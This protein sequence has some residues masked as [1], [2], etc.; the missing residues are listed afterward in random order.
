MTL[1]ALISNGQFDSII[2]IDNKIDSLKKQKDY[3][4]DSVKSSIENEISILEKDLQESKDKI[5]LNTKEKAVK[6]ELQLKSLEDSI[7]TIEDSF[8]RREYNYIKSSLVGHDKLSELKN[9]RNIILGFINL[10]MSVSE[11]EKKELELEY[12]D[13][14]SEMWEKK[15]KII[16][17][18]E[19]FYDT[20]IL[21]LEKQKEQ[22]TANNP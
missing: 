16:T 4:I 15:D 21:S 14:K 8:F 6:Y 1:F 13:K 11:I 3:K 17:K 7:K 5:E 18:L 12:I 22:L 2:E 20:E 10:I 19:S 9:K